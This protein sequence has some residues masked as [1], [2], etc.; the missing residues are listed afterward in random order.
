MI[1]GGWVA[2]WRVGGSGGVGGWRGGW[3]LEGE[4]VVWG[5]GCGGLISDTQ[6]AI[7]SY[8]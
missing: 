7:L 5:G 2:W 3:W 4:L 8:K 1:V 6:L